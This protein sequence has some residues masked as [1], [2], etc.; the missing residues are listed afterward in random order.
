MVS[1]RMPQIADYPYTTTVETREDFVAALDRAVRES[2]DPQVYREFLQKN[3]WED[4]SRELLRWADEICEQA[5]C[6]KTF[7]TK[8]RTGEPK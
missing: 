6:E 1:L 8:G 7:N 2:P 3:T 4:R 5:S